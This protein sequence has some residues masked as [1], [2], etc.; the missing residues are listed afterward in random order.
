MQATDFKDKNRSHGT[1]YSGTGFRVSVDREGKV[2]LPAEI[3]NRYGLHAGAE[4]FID[5][6]TDGLR[7]RLPVTHLAKVYV[8]PTNRCN[9]E[10]RTCI[11]NGWDEPLGFMTPGIY[12]RILEGLGG[13]L[14]LPSI[15][16]GSFGEPLFHPEIT[17]MVSRAKAL[18]ARVELIT[19]GTLL[20]RDMSRGLIEAGLDLLWVSLDGAT[21]ESYTD[22]RLGAALPE[23][24]NNVSEF[25]SLCHLHS[26][27]RPE[28]G[29]AFVAMKRNI[30]DLPSVLSIGSR[31][32]ARHF[33]VTNILPYSPEMR[34]EVLYSR[35][36]S[37]FV[38]G[39]PLELPKMD[40]N[41][42]TREAF[43]RILRCGKNVAYPGNRLE[44]ANNRCPFIEK[45]ATA[46]S[47]EGNV[48]P[49]LPLL[50]THTDYLEERERFARRYHVGNL[51][52]SGLLELW[53]QPEYVALRERLKN[54]DFS[55]C[56]VCGGCGLSEKN[57][58]DCFGNEFP[59]CGGCLWAQGLIQCP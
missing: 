54:F 44:E 41:E 27:R 3:I 42:I 58:E 51:A 40:M 31:L 32:G 15:F 57:E 49:C 33:M 59:T 53:N 35:A 37:D 46:I 16:F 43:Y 5:E 47:W 48:S 30:Q 39:P 26:S 55:P 29:V 19:N 13:F 34:E 22:V 12:S 50:H 52:E 4:F 10:C 45:G 25:R 1:Q 18:G 8:E 14:P 36:I 6:I 11:R 21:P 24:I 38:Y 28:L 2:I 56:H 17:D 9:L 23:V 20:T 7:I